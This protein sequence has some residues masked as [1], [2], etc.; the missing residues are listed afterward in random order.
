MQT[1][2]ELS[3]TLDMLKANQANTQMR[4]H[5]PVYNSVSY[6]SNMPSVEIGQLTTDVYHK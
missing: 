5:K 6:L 2:C 1:I 4:N 3:E